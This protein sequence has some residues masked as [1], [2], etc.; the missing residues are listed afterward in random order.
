MGMTKT[1]NTKCHFC[2][3]PATAVK[4]EVT[5]PIE[6][7]DTETVELLPICKPCNEKWYDGTEDRPALLPL[8]VLG[9]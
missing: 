2:Q 4:I 7:E 1:E 9:A 6:D 5:P 3:G 8:G